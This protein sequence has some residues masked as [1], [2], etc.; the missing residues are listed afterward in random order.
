MTAVDGMHLIPA[1]N[2]EL[3]AVQESLA[4]QARALREYA[5][6][7]SFGPGAPEAIEATAKAAAIDR[8]LARGTFFEHEVTTTVLDTIFGSI[9]GWT[10]GATVTLVLCKGAFPHD[11]E[12]WA[13]LGDYR[14]P[15]GPLRLVGLSNEEE[16]ALASSMQVK[17]PD[18]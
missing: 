16:Q 10:P 18:P 14:E 15:D 12:V 7:V 3:K 17:D 2:A 13:M 6:D 9:P 4:E 11:A 1:D 8:V 5:G